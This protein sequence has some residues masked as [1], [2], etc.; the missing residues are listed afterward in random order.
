MEE[1]RISLG[2]YTVKKN[3]ES[4]SDLDFWLSKTYKERLYALESL[5]RQFYS[6]SHESPPR[7][8][9]VYRITSPSVS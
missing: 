6:Y 1:Y 7:L 5:R 8:Q 3:S 4:Q 9:R 2:A